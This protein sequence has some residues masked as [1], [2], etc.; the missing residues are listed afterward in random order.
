MSS[1]FFITILS[2]FWLKS[3]ISVFLYSHI[4]SADIC[5]S[6]I[7]LNYTCPFIDAINTFK[8]RTPNC[9]TIADLSV[10]S[11]LILIVGL[12]IRVLK[13]RSVKNVF[14]KQNLNFFQ[15]LKKKLLLHRKTSWKS[16][17]DSLY[18]RRFNPSEYMLIYFRCKKR[19]SKI[20]LIHITTSNTN[21]I[22]LHLMGSEAS[23]YQW[24]LI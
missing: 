16:Q 13:L 15:F 23:L 9:L 14:V 12:K 7:S 18:Q 19:I 3:C 10:I 20:S 2:I 8:I 1:I 17:D 4:K 22:N 21:D 11:A 6:H 24:H 5:L